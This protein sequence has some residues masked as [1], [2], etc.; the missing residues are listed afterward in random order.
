[1]FDS[2]PEELAI[3][4]IVEAAECFAATDRAS[5]VS[6][7][8]TARYV[9]RMVRPI[10]LRRVFVTKSYHHHVAEALTG[11]GVGPLV[12]DLTISFREWEP[13][14]EVISCLE[15]LRCIRG[16]PY[17]M[18]KAISLLLRSTRES[19]RDV[20]S[21]SESLLP[22]VPRHVTHICAYIDRASNPLLECLLNWLSLAQFITHIGAELVD[23]RDLAFNF[24][25]DAFVRE[26]QRVLEAG[27]SRLQ[28]VAFR[29]CGDPAGDSQ[30]EQLLDALKSWSRG[31]AMTAIQ[32]DRRVALWRD[33]RSLMHLADDIE[34][35]LNDS[36]AGVDIWSEARILAEW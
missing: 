24:Q 8:L 34:A 26:L 20:Q 23:R 31:S 29:I 11:A 28:L 7:A 30:W 16:R 17:V 6:L 15:N 2:L 14:L 10:L 12:L 18:S 36:L 25:P 5:A 1:M 19:L 27:G 21:W 4:I 35:S 33:Q 9:Y 22:Y 32:A 13:T 3:A